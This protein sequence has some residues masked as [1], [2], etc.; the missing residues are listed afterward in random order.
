MQIFYIYLQMMILSTM[1]FAMK[2]NYLNSWVNL[3]DFRC[4]Y[5][6]KEFIS[7]DSLNNNQC[8]FLNLKMVTENVGNIQNL[9]IIH[10]KEEEYWPLD[11]NSQLVFIISHL[12][13]RWRDLFS[14]C[15]KIIE[16][17]T[18]FVH[19]HIQFGCI[20]IKNLKFYYAND[21]DNT[22]FINTNKY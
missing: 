19:L 21:F 4:Y 8:V 13:Q 3:E 22:L 6:C 11:L 17:Q 20:F 18:C 14:F 16:S 12:I 2:V 15:N 1:L 5:V 7:N 9:Y 10:K